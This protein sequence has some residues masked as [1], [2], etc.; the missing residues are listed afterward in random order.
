MNYATYLSRILNATLILFS[1]LLLSA[2]DETHPDDL[3]GGVN[4]P[5][6]EASVA[7]ESSVAIEAADETLVFPVAVTLS[8]P[9]PEAGEVRYRLVANTATEGRDYE[10]TGSTVSFAE[11]ERQVQI[12]LQLLNDESRS[13]AR[14]LI[15]ELTGATNATLGASVSQTITIEPRGQSEGGSEQEV[16]VLNLPESLSFIAPPAGSD[17]FSVVIPFS[18]SLLEDSGVTIHTVSG[19]ALENEHY[20]EI[21]GTNCS[22]SVCNAEQGADELTFFLTLIGD[23]D[24][25]DRSFRL[26]FLAADGFDLPGNREVEVTVSYPDSS[27]SATPELLIPEQLSLR[28]PTA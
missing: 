12:Q 7:P 14:E 10:V 13:S 18:N 2:C 21:S 22:G 15:L 16:P 20:G 24:A 6:P 26:Q 4:N 5:Y 11:G 9:A 3:P 23:T 27:A 17:E 28:L 1:L 8:R 19:S 25:E